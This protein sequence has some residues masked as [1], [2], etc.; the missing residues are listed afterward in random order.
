MVCTAALSYL[1]VICLPRDKMIK[2]LS[3]PKH[4]V[5]RRIVRKANVFYTIRA[6]IIE[7]GPTPAETLREERRV[8]ATTPGGLTTPGSRSSMW[9]SFL[10]SDA[11][12]DAE[13]RESRARARAARVHGKRRRSLARTMTSSLPVAQ[14]SAA[15]ALSIPS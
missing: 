10:N 7:I 2:L 8:A 12:F 9:H 5:E 13:G 14:S 11:A 6:R 1:E 4:E 15:R 3:I